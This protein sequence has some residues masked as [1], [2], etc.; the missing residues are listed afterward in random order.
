MLAQ[1][2]RSH[3]QYHHIGEAIRLEAVRAHKDPLLGF[4]N[5][6]AVENIVRFF[7]MLTWFGTN[8]FDGHIAESSSSPNEVVY[9]WDRHFV[10]ICN[11]PHLNARII[12]LQAYGRYTFRRNEAIEESGLSP[13]Y[14]PLRRRLWT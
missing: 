6:N 9:P 12:A 10:Q 7:A 3:C 13:E 5:T 1:S 4:V 14:P 8:T 11:S 2:R